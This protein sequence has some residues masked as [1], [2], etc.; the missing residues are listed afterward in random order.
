MLKKI[1]AFL[2]SPWFISFLGATLIAVLAWFFG[3]MIGIGEAHPLDD[4]LWRIVVIVVIYAIW[5]LLNLRRVQTARKRDK[6]L[7]DAIAAKTGVEPNANETATAEELAVLGDRLKEALT[8]LKTLKSGG[9][10]SKFT[11]GGYLYQLPWYMFIGP[12]GAGKTTAL[13]NS[14]LNFPLSETFGNAGLRGVGGTRNCDWWFA[15]EAI[16]LDTAGRYTTQDSNT[17]VDSK[18]WLGF[19]GML[20]RFRPRQPINGVVVSISLSDLATMSDTERAAHGR[21]IK[22]RLRELNDELGVRFPI[23]VQ[24]T[25][26]DLIAGFVEFFDA[27]GKEEREQVWGMT[28]PLDQGKDEGGP[29]AN[30]LPEFD[31][32]VQRLTDRVVERMQQETDIQRRSLIYGFPQQFASLRDVANTLLLDIFRPNRLEP[33]LLLRGV[34]FTSGTQDGTPIDRLLGAMAGQFG[35]QRQA[36]SA[37]S[38]A[39]R[40]Y[41]LTR[42]MREVVFNE[43]GVVGLDPKV[44]AR[45]KLK[46]RLTFAACGLA[47]VLSTGFW[48]NSYFINRGMV[49]TTRDLVAQYNEQFR[50]ITAK[51]GDPTDLALLA[52]ALNTLRDLPSGY[53]RREQDPPTSA[54]FGLY[55]GYRLGAEDVD[56]YYR[57]LNNVLLPR[58][59]ARVERQLKAQIAGSP[60]FL[61][62]GLKVYLILGRLGPLDA[63]LVEQWLGA[64]IEASYP[65][66]DQQKLVEDL[67]GH[68]HALLQRPV[69]QIALNGPLVE[70]VRNVLRRQPTAERSYLRIL[71]SEKTKELTEW[72]VS[73]HAGA[74]A[75][76][77]MGLRS[78]KP[79]STG[80]PGIYTWAG[81]HDVFLSLLPD[82]TDDIAEDSWVLGNQDKID[83]TRIG[84]LRRDVL[85]LYYADYERKWDAL[86]ADVVVKP[87]TSVEQGLDALN[88]L[89]GPN[90]PLRMFLQ[91]VS[92]ETYLSREPST[93]KSAQNVAA[94]AT[95]LAPSE[96][97]RQLSQA[98]LST[99]QRVFIMLFSKAALNTGEAQKFVDPA[100]RVDEHFKGIRAFVGTAEKPGELENVLQKLAQLYQNFGQLAGAPDKGAALLGAAA[101]G[102]GSMSGQLAAMAKTLP[103]PVDA[104]V[105]AVAQSSAAVTSSGSKQQISDAWRANVLPLCDAAFA[106]RYPFVVSSPIDVPIDD[107]TR[108]IGPGGL[109]DQF[110][111]QNLKPFVN[112]V[113]KPWKW[114]GPDLGLS[115][116]ALGQMQRAA[117]MRDGLFAG[118]PAMSVKFEMVPVSLDAGI[119]QVSVDI[120]GQVLTYNHGPMQ[121]LKMAWP[122]ANG[123][124]QVRVTLT[125]AAGG[126]GAVI[127]RSGPWALFRLFDAAKITASGQADRFTVTFASGTQNAAFQVTSS[128]VINP[129][130][131]PALHQFRCPASF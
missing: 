23:Y 45:Q 108:I 65:E 115:N 80:I 40:S 106:N 36:V 101:A 1:A 70:Q 29:V 122:V 20:K 100:T 116:D 111:A 131:M 54:T 33:R 43:A 59:L 82:I 47:L 72:R 87:F 90:S 37:F 51:K 81:Y 68:V 124:G 32:L 104:M 10:L 27:L 95:K 34:Y 57:V 123:R 14:G 63:N 118:A 94:A 102:G 103:K 64:D 112:I 55:Q 25:K 125:A 7:M 78:G 3:P 130:T 71:R 73:D 86:L 121:P 96:I 12:P 2:L 97:G 61:Y 91:S 19:L 129:F 126:Q 75:N 56:G 113:S 107:F 114:Q 84:L 105:A 31:A 92:L 99:R 74:A 77:V 18:S 49:N 127:E 93:D 39:G 15:D 128:S 22:K 6:A 21:A 88:I 117:E 13:V 109:I 62:E 69:T 8:A 53:A 120:D 67:K 24:F 5:L 35:L 50:A 52:P 44:E 30:F 46:M 119:A 89:S 11:G 98:G 76:Q 28:F 17:E 48:V 79:L 16:L 38:G 58:L 85:G 42:L 83:R 9:L 4:I 66:D 41:F 60:D 110:F 26:A